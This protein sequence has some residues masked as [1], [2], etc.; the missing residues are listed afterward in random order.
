[1]MIA[2]VYHIIFIITFNYNEMSFIGSQE[3][4]YE[5]MISG[6][7]NIMCIII[8]IRYMYFLLNVHSLY[9]GKNVL[10]ETNSI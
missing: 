6:K 7:S 1:M 10:L 2:S 9:K 5:E 4:S 8:F 3:E